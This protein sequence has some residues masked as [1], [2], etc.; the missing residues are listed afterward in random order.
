MQEHEAQE[1]L[2]EANQNYHLP[3]GSPG[4]DAAR[5]KIPDRHPLHSEPAPSAKAL[6]RPAAG[7]LDLGAFET[8]VDN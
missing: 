3:P 5:G 6:N 7:P 8:Q 2:D 4:I 1:F